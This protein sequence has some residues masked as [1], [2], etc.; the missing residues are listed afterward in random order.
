MILFKVFP[1]P[2]D[3]ALAAAEEIASE[4][5]K[6]TKRKSRSAVAVSGG[7]TP[8]LL[9]SVLADKYRNRINWANVNLFW[10]DER[11]V[12]PD[13]PESNFGMT[14]RNLLSKV[15]IP[16]G[17]I[18]RMRGEADPQQE[19]ERYSEVVGRNVRMR[20]G[21][22]VFDLV[23][24]GM[25]EDGHTASIFPGNDKLMTSDKICETSV[26]PVTKQRRITLTGK[27]INNARSVYFLV[28]GKKKSGIVEEIYRNNAGVQKYPAANIKPV[29]GKTTWLLDSE[30]GMFIF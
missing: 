5:E 10:V 3:L 14:E 11:C 12:A 16:S 29:F 22:P 30:A 21:F 1:T 13:D 17:N 4:L 18:F 26:H 15:E 9:F 7:N 28:T 2:E 8:A 20:K 6:R 25:G 19:A 24:L 23:L 27:V